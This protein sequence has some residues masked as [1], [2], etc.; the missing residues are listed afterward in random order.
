[1]FYIIIFYIFTA[2]EPDNSFIGFVVGNQT[3]S[4][5]DVKKN[6]NIAYIYGKDPE[7]IE[8]SLVL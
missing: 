7:Y 6:K 8:V 5:M 1:M 4:E 2:L 3:V